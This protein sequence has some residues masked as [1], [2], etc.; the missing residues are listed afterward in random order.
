MRQ[1]KI[2]GPP[3]M[4]KSDISRVRQQKHKGISKKYDREAGPMEKRNMIE[5]DEIEIDLIQFFLEL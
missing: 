1:S 2:S 4:R 3:E 5:N